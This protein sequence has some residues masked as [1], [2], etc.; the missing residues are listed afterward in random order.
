MVDAGGEVDLG[1]LEWVVGGKVDGQKENAAGVWT[2][3]LLY[4]V[5]HRSRY[6]WG[7]RVRGRWRGRWVD[8]QCEK[9]WHT[10]P[11]IVACQWNYGAGLVSIY[12]NT[13]SF[14]NMDRSSPKSATQVLPARTRTYQ[15][16]SDRS[17]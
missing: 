3:P 8:D 12:R 5:N 10:G 14:P 9:G 15:I 16:I 6:S 13:S 7:T 11:I 17:C 2:V 4:N 1:W